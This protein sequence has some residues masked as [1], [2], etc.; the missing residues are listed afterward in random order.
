MHPLKLL[1]SITQSSKLP[2]RFQ[3]FRSDLRQFIPAM[4]EN[5]DHVKHKNIHSKWV[6]EIQRL[7]DDFGAEKLSRGRRMMR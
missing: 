3:K 5:I 4:Y 2:S 6:K 7:K 1:I